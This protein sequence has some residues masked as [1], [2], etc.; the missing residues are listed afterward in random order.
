MNMLKKAA[1]I[2]FKEGIVNYI[3]RKR[4]ITYLDNKIVY[5]IQYNN[6][7]TKIKLNRE[8]GFVD[9]QIFKNGIY[10]KDIIDDIFAKLS[11]EKNLIDIGANI[12]QHSLL[13]APYV[14][15]IYAFEP[16]PKVYE[17]FKDSIAKSLYKY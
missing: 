7:P 12:G 17:Q 4:N 8:F 11:L 3:K 9:L 5:T 13:L 2:L 1:S 14:R 16:I 6:K 15:K 10:E